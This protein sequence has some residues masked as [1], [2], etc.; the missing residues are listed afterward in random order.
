MEK[1]DIWWNISCKR[2]QQ[3][4]HPAI[5]LTM[6]LWRR[7]LEKTSTNNKLHTEKRKKEIPLSVSRY[8]PKSPVVESYYISPHDL[9][10]THLKGLPIHSGKKCDYAIMRVSEA[11]SPS[12]HA[13]ASHAENKKCNY[14]KKRV[15]P[16][17]WTVYRRSFVV[18]WRIISWLGNLSR[19]WFCATQRIYVILLL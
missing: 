14:T 11:V 7:S 10:P 3:R 13:Q 17:Y 1:S 15:A 12:T 5:E 18:K 4:Y 8:R 16:T 2:A 9:S 6:S 19:V